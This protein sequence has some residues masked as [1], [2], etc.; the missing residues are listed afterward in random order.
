ALIDVIPFDITKAW[1]ESHGLETHDDVY[2]YGESLYKA[3]KT[4]EAEQ[5]DI[6]ASDAGKSDDNAATD[7]QG[8]PLNEDGTLKLEKIASV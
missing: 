2:S 6:P 5:S 1:C 3:E 4:V 8:N 7:N